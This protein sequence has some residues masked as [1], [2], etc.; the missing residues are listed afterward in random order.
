VRVVNVALAALLCVSTVINL[1][2]VGRVRSLRWNLEVARAAMVLPVGEELPILSATDSSGKPVS[3]DPRASD[4]P[5]LLYVLSPTC[6]WCTLN[7]DSINHLA[8]NVRG[9]FRVVAVSL[10]KPTDGLN[11]EYSYGFPVLFEPT[12]ESIVAYRLRGTPQTL[13]IS[14][15]G[16]LENSWKGAYIG[17]VKRSLEARFGTALPELTPAAAVAAGSR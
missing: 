5:T 3:L 13:L 4:L 7:R 12:E 2:L 10:S 8:S 9:E 1:L 17:E 11:S 6:G 15:D 16:K 14:K